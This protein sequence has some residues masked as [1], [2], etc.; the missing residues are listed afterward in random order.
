M[1]GTIVET[2]S[3]AVYEGRIGQNACRASKGGVVPM[4]LPV[5]WNTGRAGC[6]RHG[7]AMCG[8]RQP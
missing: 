6:R 3:I 5:G 4:T 8:F 1:R 2:S 7:T